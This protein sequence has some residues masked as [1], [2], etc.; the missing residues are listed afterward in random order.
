M[1]ALALG[2][3]VAVVLAAVTAGGTYAFLRSSAQSAG[4]TLVGGTATLVVTTPLALP[5][6]ALYPGQT[7]SG[8]GTVR[9]TGAVPLRLRIAGLTQSTTVNPFTSALTVGVAIG[10]SA[11]AC[12]AGFTP[13][14]TATFAAVVPTELTVRLAPG[15][16]A[17]VCVSVSLPLDAPAGANAQAGAGFSLVLDGR[18]V[19]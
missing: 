11:A 2:A 10:A 16:S 4:A 7:V 8:S 9:N 3:T 17:V 14:W 1:L 6:T 15:D 18:Q 19:P 5:S 12:S 13:T